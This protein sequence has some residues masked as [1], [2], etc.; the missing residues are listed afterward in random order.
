[1][2]DK[3]TREAREQ[4]KSKQKHDHDRHDQVSLDGL[5]KLKFTMLDEDCQYLFAMAKNLT[6]LVLTWFIIQVFQEEIWIFWSPQKKN[7]KEN[8]SRP[9]TH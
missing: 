1:M 2:R 7:A 4:K 5:G 9:T 6:F 3:L 8:P